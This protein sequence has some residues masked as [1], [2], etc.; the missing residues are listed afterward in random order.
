M[1][2]SPQPRA[3]R[4]GL[5]ASKPKRSPGREVSSAKEQSSPSLLR[6]KAG[7]LSAPGRIDAASIVASG[8]QYNAG[9]NDEE[10]PTAGEILRKN[11]IPLAA[12]F[13]IN[14]T[15][16]IV[17]GIVSFSKPQR[18][19]VM[20]QASVEKPPESTGL[21]TQSMFAPSDPIDV[22]DIRPLAK[23]PD[24][25]KK[26]DVPINAMG[27]GPQVANIALPS[28]IPT[29]ALAGRGQIK[30]DLLN[31]YQGSR[32]TE[33]AVEMGLLWLANHQLPSGLW[34]LTGDQQGGK[35]KYSRGAEIENQE[36]ATAMAL[37]A[38]FGAGQTPK[39][40][41]HAKVI[42]K[43]VK[44]L[45]RLQDAKGVFFHGSQSQDL[46]YTQAL[47]TMAACEL[48]ALDP[49]NSDLRSPCEKAVA[50]CLESQ[51]SLGGWKYTPR[52]DADV[53]VTGWMLMALQSAK[54]AKLDVPQKVFDDIGKFLDET[55]RGPLTPQMLID[56]TTPPA[57]GSPP[58]GSRYAYM[59]G[60]NHDAVM[61]AEGLLC[62]MYLGWAPDDERLR[63]GCEYLLSE[64]LPAWE[65]RDVYYWYYG[66]QL[67]FHM[68]GTFWQRWNGV[69]RDMLVKRQEKAGAERGSWNPMG[70]GQGDAEGADR[71]SLLHR[72][73]RLYVT[74][75]SVYMLEVYYRHLPLYSELKKQI[76]AKQAAAGKR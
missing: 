18:H 71:W 72:G 9:K 12:S 34:S 43:G 28:D 50:F 25:P 42:D 63:N 24:L 47:C 32:A 51:S 55:A 10:A 5:A 52:V 60:D 76:Q 48:L 11:A 46:L 29:A 61:T 14:L 35:G 30:G 58:L 16:I 7:P 54:N 33:E 38:F 45:L 69:L 74:A 73:G 65:A 70:T 49:S 66:T 17:L 57:A 22:I 36:A 37:L 64:E 13:L 20:I 23:L 15:A 59:V 19:I 40:G 6:L 3:D 4:E 56:P 31:K 39:N 26:V 67:M 44:A 68:E 2:T 27:I 1:P 21:D 41:L 8:P 62:R 53:S 75:F